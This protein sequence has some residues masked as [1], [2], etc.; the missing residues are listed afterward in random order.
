MLAY[1]RLVDKVVV[2]TGGGSG[3]GRALAQGYASQGSVVWV[4]GRGKEALEE[5]SKFAD[6]INYAVC[7]ISDYENVKKVIAGIHTESGRIDILINGLMT[8]VIVRIN[9]S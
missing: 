5:T 4:L 7:D 8:D 2:I 6:S 3:L 1:K 9:Y